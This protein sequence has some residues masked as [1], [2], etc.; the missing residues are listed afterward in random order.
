MSGKRRLEIRTGKERFVRILLYAVLALLLPSAAESAVLYVKADATGANNGS[1]WTDAFKELRD[2]LTAAIP[3][4]QIRAAS[5]I[6]TPAAG[7]DRTIS[8]ALKDGVAVYGGFAGG[9]TSLEQRDWTVNVAVLSGNI[10]DPASADDNSYHVVTADGGTGPGAILDGFTITGGYADGGSDEQQRGGGMFNNGGSPSTGNCIFT[11]N[12]AILGGGMFNSEAAATVAHCTFSGNAALMGGDMFNYKGSPRVTNCLFL[13]NGFMVVQGGGMYNSESSPAIVDCTF[14]G[15]TASHGGGMYNS[16]GAP[17]ITGCVFSGHAAL[18]GGGMFNDSSSVTASDCAFSGNFA[19]SGGG[20]YNKES[21]LAASGCLF[22]GNGSTSG[23]GLYNHDDGEVSLTNCTFSENN[24][25]LEGG[26]V[27]NGGTLVVVNCTFSDNVGTDGGIRRQNGVVAVANSI[28]W[29]G[30]DQITA[31]QTVEHSVVE[32][33]YVGL[34]NTG[35]DPEL[36]PLS[37]NGGPTK[38]HALGPG[39]SALGAGLPSGTP[40]AGSVV[41]DKD[42]RGLPRPE[43]PAKVDMGAYQTQPVPTPTPPP[44]PAPNPPPEPEPDPEPTPEP[45]PTPPPAQGPRP[46][47]PV[48][49]PAIPEGTPWTSGSFPTDGAP[50][51]AEPPLP[52]TPEQTKEAIR[53]ALRKALVPE[54]RIEAIIELLDIDESGRI[55]IAPEGIERMKTVLEGLNIPE[56]ATEAPIAIFIALL[57]GDTGKTAADDAATAILFFTVPESFRGKSAESLYVVKVFSA[58][59]AEPFVQAFSFEELIDGRSAVVEF[60]NIEG[61]HELKRVLGRGDAIS[62]DCRIA[63][64][65]K[66][67][68]RF[69]LDGAANDQVVD[70]AFVTEAAPKSGPDTPSRAEEGGGCT[71]GGSPAAG[72]SLLPLLLL[73]LLKTKKRRDETRPEKE[74]RGGV[75]PKGVL[76]ANSRPAGRDARRNPDRG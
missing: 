38:T 39:S 22:S 29:G 67:G 15:N 72:S 27:Y 36:L 51:I 35:L 23:G 30:S 34:G 75:R 26:G 73:L 70:P 76:R 21:A 2:A 50:L 11:G 32:G 41:P 43:A 7:A 8:F 52:A 56:G 64:A 17:A 19:A 58:E 65:L 1:S 62:S 12:V 53:I 63:L 71:T 46:V 10:G 5:G 45:S 69:D 4:D 37:D 66:D 24:A 74:N 20:I 54:D 57:G 18:G 55:F 6:Y 49:V 42:Q 33:G 16:K 47:L 59:A 68:G 14:S 40:V 3:G 28:F 61:K 48:P 60:A 31:G 13:A 9:E 44:T 25:G